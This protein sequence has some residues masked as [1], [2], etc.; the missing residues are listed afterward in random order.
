MTPIRAHFQAV[1]CGA[2]LLLP[3]TALAATD[4]AALFAKKCSGCHTYGKGDRVGPDLKGVADRR[5]RAW[6]TSWIRSSQKVVEAGDPIATTL[7]DKYKRERMPDQNLPA[8]DI[9]ALVDY[10]AAGG[11]AAADASRPRHASTATLADIALGREL[12]LGSIAAKNGGASCGSCHVVQVDGASTGATFGSD[13]THVYSRF[14]DAALSLAL[15]RPCFPRAFDKDTAGPL[16]ADE[17]F[18]VKAFL[19]QADRA[20]SPQRP[21]G[22]PR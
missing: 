12:F 19:R 15:R 22:R 13:L 3:V 8:E 16:T 17:A 9:A 11:P 20:A 7:F 1:I 6:L 4:P 2:A 10:L 5:S 21:K 14:Q 18:A